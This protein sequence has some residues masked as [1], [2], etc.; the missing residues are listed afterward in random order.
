MY[1]LALYALSRRLLK[2]VQVCGY[3][4]FPSIRRNLNSLR[5]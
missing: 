1:C 2:E 3:S 4:M 5:P